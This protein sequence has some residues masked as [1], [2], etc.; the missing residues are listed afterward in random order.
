MG[1]VLLV[2]RPAA[3]RLAAAR[4]SDALSLAYLRGRLDAE[5]S[6]VAARVDLSRALVGAGRLGEARAVLRPSVGVDE[7]APIAFA[8]L[9]VC[10]EDWR[11]RPAGSPDRRQMEGEL[12]SRLRALPGT[13]AASDLETAAAIALEAT[14]PADAAAL[15]VKAADA[16][17]HARQGDRTALLLQKAGDA[18]LASGDPDRGGALLARAAL[19]GGPGSTERA[20]A[21]L[22]TL[23]GAREA[24]PALRICDDLVRNLGDAAVLAAAVETAQAHGDLAQAL[25]YSALRLRQAP[26]DAAAL[27]KDLTLQLAAGHLGAALDRAGRLAALVPS[28]ARQWQVVQLAVWNQRPDLALSVLTRLA[29]EGDAEA[30]AQGAALASTLGRPALEVELLGGLLRRRPGS[31]AQL[32]RFLSLLREAHPARALPELQEYVQRNPSDAPARELLALEAEQQGELELALQQRE[33]LP[34]ERRMVAEITAESALLWRLG[35]PAEA[36]QRLHRVRAQV[37]KGDPTQRAYWQLLAE[38][39]WREEAWADLESAYEAQRLLGAIDATGEERLLILARKR[40]EDD[41]VLT[42]GKEGYGRLNA[43]RLLLLA[44]DRAVEMGRWDAAAELAREA[45]GDPRVIE[46][47]AGALLFLQIALHEGRAH[48]AALHASQALKVAPDSR[49]AR[50][51]LL[52]AAYASREGPLM[53]HAVEALK[54]TARANPELWAPMALLLQELR[55]PGEALFFFE[56]QLERAPQDLHWA[57]QTAEARAQ[58]GQQ[59]SARALRQ[60]LMPRLLA[61][62]QKPTLSAAARTEL[63]ADA[64]GLLRAEQGIDAALPVLRALARDGEPG[65]AAE[66]AASWAIEEEKPALA[67]EFAPP[68]SSQ[69]R[70]L[71]PNQQ[72]E[73]S[74][75]EGDRPAIRALL[76]QPGVPLSAPERVEAEERLGRDWAAWD[77]VR[78]ALGGPLAPAD[79]ARLHEQEQELSRRVASMARVGTEVERMGPL[80][81]ART[82]IEGRLRRGPFLTSAGAQ[83]GSFL[84]GSAAPAPQRLFAAAEFSQELGTTRLQGGAD[85]RAGT[86]RPFASAAQTLQPAPWIKFSLEGVLRGLPDE[87]AG[88]RAVGLRDRA[89][90]QIE[91]TQGKSEL[92]ATVGGRRYAAFADGAALGTAQAAEL[93]VARRLG[94]APFEMAALLLGSFESGQPQPR[95]SQATMLMPSRFAQAGGGFNISVD[96]GAL[97]PS[98][99][100][101]AEAF[102]GYALPVDRPVARLQA[103]IG[104]LF[105][106]HDELL[107]TGFAAT[108]AGP[109]AEPSA[110]LHLDVL[111]RFPF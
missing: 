52:W 43:P 75:L 39:A 95:S 23:R 4:S 72:L 38:L 56:R 8:E 44:I 85:L 31:A 11:S 68:G 26:D 6:S 28:P 7:P 91:L 65:R 87:S 10:A 15:F 51:G 92:R 106:R 58:A 32:Q 50:E 94:R 103:R 12:V 59:K 30:A 67:A 109:A 21:A 57:V 66:L 89:D 82:D 71:P 19:L 83:L 81:E 61:A 36:L 14:R 84:A 17:D 5:P 42:L 45:H 62:A 16:A 53:A 48:D 102:L 20:L 79:A 78:A 13:L 3:D 33:R 27:E 88:L 22:R 55:R 105:T 104:W 90:L 77:E 74:L 73:L 69:R 24:A 60:S 99:E 111:H 97:H 35:R 47:E 2:M 29:R 93:E 40:G 1:A 46:T 107:L 70:A 37:H 98:I 34:P 108:L 110:G 41:R 76:L 86:A 9:L 64:A 63:R 80:K 25:R 49:Q 100:V 96:P 54:E 18:S 101:V